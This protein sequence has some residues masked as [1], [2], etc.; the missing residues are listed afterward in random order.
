MPTPTSAADDDAKKK[1]RLA[2]FAAP[3]SKTDPAEEDK[4]KARALRCVFF[5]IFVFPF[6]K[7]L[8]IIGIL[9]G[10]CVLCSQVFKCIIQTFVSSQ[11]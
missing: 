6:H 10:Y 3:G 9:L 1:A 5:S 11:F 2:R 4:K 8:C 7:E